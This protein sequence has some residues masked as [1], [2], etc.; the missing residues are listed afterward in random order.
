MTAQRQ[1][2]AA[3]FGRQDLSGIDQV[4]LWVDGIHLQVRLE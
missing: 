3:A 4:Y 2:E 1:D